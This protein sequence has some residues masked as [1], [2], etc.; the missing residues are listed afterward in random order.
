PPETDPEPELDENA[1]LTRMI[2]D[3]V[4]ATAHEVDRTPEFFLTADQL[5]MIVPGHP[6]PVTPPEPLDRQLWSLESASSEFPEAGLAAEPVRPARRDRKLRGEVALTLTRT[7]LDGS[8]NGHE[9]WYVRTFLAGRELRAGTPLPGPEWLR[10][11]DF[12]TR[13]GEHFDLYDR[14]GDI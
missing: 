2:L 8:K 9:L 10:H 7:L 12:S 14:V 1:D 11:R 4:I 13:W 6:A 5:T 3:S